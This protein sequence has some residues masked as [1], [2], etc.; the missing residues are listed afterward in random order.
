MII[1]PSY[2]SFCCQFPLDRSNYENNKNYDNSLLGLPWEPLSSILDRM[3]LISVLCWALTC[4][5][6]WRMGWRVPPDMLCAEEL[7]LLA[8]GLDESELEEKVSDQAR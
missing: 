6:A 5:W 1:K 7:E 4:R 2:K 3:D 8:S